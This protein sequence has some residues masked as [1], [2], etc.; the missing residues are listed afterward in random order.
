MFKSDILKEIIITLWQKLPQYVDKKLSKFLI[1]QLNKFKARYH[2]KKY[3]P[4]RETRVINLV[5]I[6]KKLYKIQ[7]FVNLYINK[8]IYN[9]D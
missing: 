2:I 1:G 3:K 5:V 7:E 4:Y 6:K 9:M 8:N